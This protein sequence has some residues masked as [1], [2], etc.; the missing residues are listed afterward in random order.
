MYK[1]K[2]IALVLCLAFVAG[3][4]QQK[5]QDNVPQMREMADHFYLL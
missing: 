5:G 1:I 3:A 2:L 4:C